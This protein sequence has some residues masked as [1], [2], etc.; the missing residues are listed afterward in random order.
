MAD[1]NDLREDEIENIDTTQEE[2][3]PD[4]KAR[5]QKRNEVKANE[6]PIQIL[7]Q[8]KSLLISSPK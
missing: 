6:E 7:M 4:K 1:K 2:N 5:K 8:I 3:L